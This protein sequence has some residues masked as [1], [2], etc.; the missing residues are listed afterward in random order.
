[1]DLQATIL[2][3]SNHIFLVGMKTAVQD[4][5]EWGLPVLDPSYT[6]TSI[7]GVRGRSKKVVFFCVL[8]HLHV[9]CSCS[10]V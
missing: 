1:M 2:L 8:S 6:H 9:L 7:T 4:L 5:T 3:H 10:A